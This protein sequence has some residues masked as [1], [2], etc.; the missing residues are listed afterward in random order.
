MACAPRIKA[1]AKDAASAGVSQQ[2][3][4][5]HQKCVSPQLACASLR[6]CCALP[7]GDVDMYTTCAVSEFYSPPHLVSVVIVGC[8][9]SLEPTPFNEDC[10]FLMS[11]GEVCEIDLDR[12]KPFL[13]RRILCT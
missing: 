3:V 9:V 5:A 12:A 4:R 6:A 7:W 11:K 1:F 13:D 8:Y 2:R 10:S